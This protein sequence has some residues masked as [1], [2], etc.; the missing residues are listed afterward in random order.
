[1]NSEERKKVKEIAEW[2]EQWKPVEDKNDNLLV[3]DENGDV[4]PGRS[5]LMNRNIQQGAV[6]E[7]VKH[8]HPRHPDTDWLTSLSVLVRKIDREWEKT[9][10]KFP[11][12][13][14]EGRMLLISTE[15]RFNAIHSAMKEVQESER[16]TAQNSD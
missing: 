10:Q 8:N 1:M 12:Q 13:S 2:V 14:N 6:E 16:A 5:L 11:L 9:K 4:F 7:F 3:E 15:A